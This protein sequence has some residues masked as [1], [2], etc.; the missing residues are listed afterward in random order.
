MAWI[1]ALILALAL[2]VAF[3]QPVMAAVG[4]LFGYIYIQD[5]GFLPADFNN[6]APAAGLAGP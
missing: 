2:L 4:R 5:A 3:R 1:V 6:G